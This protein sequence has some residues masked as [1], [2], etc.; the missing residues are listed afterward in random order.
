MKQR[1]IVQGT[2]FP[3]PL[4]DEKR[5]IIW[6]CGLALI[7]SDV[8]D[9]HIDASSALPSGQDDMDLLPLRDLFHPFRSVKRLFLTEKV[10]RYVKYALE[11]EMKSHSLF[12]MT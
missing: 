9:L 10:A 1:C 8:Q 11:Q 4:L 2:I 12:I 3:S 7:I 6:G 5:R